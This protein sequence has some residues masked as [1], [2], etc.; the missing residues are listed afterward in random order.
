MLSRPP[1]CRITPIRTKGL[2]FTARLDSEGVMSVRLIAWPRAEQD[3]CP[4]APLVKYSTAMRRSPPQHQA[5]LRHPPAYSGIHPKAVS[6]ML[7]HADISIALDTHS[8]VM[9]GLGEVG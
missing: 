9:P 3:R 5:R 2:S 1:S 4:Q 7:G 8:H 6:E